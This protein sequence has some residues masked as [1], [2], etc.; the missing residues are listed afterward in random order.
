MSMEF[1]WFLFILTA[2]IAMFGIINVYS[3]TR[4]YGT[5]SNVKSDRSHVVL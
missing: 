1:D 2:L 4:S 5:I 3:A